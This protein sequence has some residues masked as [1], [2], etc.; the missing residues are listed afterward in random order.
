MASK[1]YIYTLSSALHKETLVSER[2]KKFLDG[3]QIEY[4]FCGSDFSTYGSADLSLIYVCTGGT[5]NQFL[6]LFGQLQKQA[7]HPFYLLTSGESNSLA[8]S[9][10]ILSYL[11]IHHLKGKILHG[12]CSYVSKRIAGLASV[13]AGRKQLKGMR[14]GI[15]GNPSDWLI[16]SNVDYAAIE[17]RLGVKFVH[18]DI[19]EVNISQAA[20][21]NSQ[22]TPCSANNVCDST[23]K[24]TELEEYRKK[25]SPLCSGD[26]AGVLRSLDGALQLYYALK[27]VV[28]RYDLQ[29]FTIRCFDLLSTYHNTGCLAL[30]RLNEE[31]IVAGC[32]GD[33]PTL[34]SM[35]VSK[36]LTGVSGFQA[37]PAQINVE[38]GEVLFAHCT[39]PFNM[40]ERYELDTHFESSIGVGI[41][42]YME[43]GFVTVFKLSPSLDHCFIAEGQLMCSGNAENLCRTQQHIRLNRPVDAQYFLKEPIGNHHVIIP[44]HVKEL[45]EQFCCTE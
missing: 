33:V 40:V 26:E 21:D 38:S 35:I 5:E 8:A 19:H 41:R 30:A 16:S 29:A 10:E 15:I 13:E 20:K 12:T 6:Q 42:G 9:M 2:T 44:G 25:V 32:E 3:L 7:S 17:E 1:I 18:V 39:I 23:S 28:N 27:D 22:S 11:H 31:G 34:L 24:E 36:V 43:E 14:I 4:T 37:N 45:L